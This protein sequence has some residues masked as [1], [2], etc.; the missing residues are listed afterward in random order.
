MYLQFHI[1][2]LQYS[3]QR[4]Y[5][6]IEDISTIQCSSYSKRCAKYSAYPSDYAMWSV[7]PAIYSVISA[8]HI[9]ASIFKWTY[10]RRYWTHVDNSASIVLQTWCQYK[11]Q[12]SACAMWTVI[13]DIYNVNMVPHILASIFKW[14]YLRCY[15]GY[16]DYSICVILQIWCQIQRTTSSLR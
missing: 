11:A 10:L 3:N 13:P 16:I 5:A 4:I 15:R 14:T 9:Q 1:F 12:P 6:A 8:L 7:V 2:R